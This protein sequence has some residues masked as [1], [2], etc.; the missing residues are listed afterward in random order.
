MKKEFKKKVVIKP[1]IRVKRKVVR[2]ETE[3]PTT[4]ILQL[5]KALVKRIR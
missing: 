3:K 5:R 2:R 4:S 1:K